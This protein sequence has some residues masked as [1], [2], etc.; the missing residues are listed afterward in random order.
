MS[1]DG[2]VTRTTNGTVDFLSTLAVGSLARSTLWTGVPMAGRRY[3][4]FARRRRQEDASLTME[5]AWSDQRRLGA[6][7]ELFSVR[8]GLE[9]HLLFYKTCH[10]LR[11]TSD[12]LQF[13]NTLCARPTRPRQHWKHGH[14]GSSSRVR[15]C[16]YR[17]LPSYVLENLAL[18]RPVSPGLV[19]FVAQ[20]R[21]AASRS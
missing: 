16:R 9:Q 3:C 14:T 4:A 6:R 1:C 12:V 11:A 7:A 5:R 8:C 10:L 17:I 2:A 19:T 18:A 21:R 13:Q 15:A 20:A